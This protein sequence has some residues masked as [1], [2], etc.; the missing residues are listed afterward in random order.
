VHSNLDEVELFLNG[1]SQGRQKVVPLTHLQWQV[2]YEPGAIEAHGFKGGKLVM[3]SRRETTGA[4]ATIRL[5][6]NRS[7]LAADG[8]DIALVRVE[9]LD[10]A[11]R[12]L[13]TA[14]NLIKFKVSGEGILLGV[15]NGDPNCQES[16]IQPQ[17]S[18]FNGLAQL[19]VQATTTPG[20]MTIE[21]Y[22][23]DFPGPKLPTARMSIT[24]RRALLRPAL[25]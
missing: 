24:T 9:V 8:A 13:P 15:G 25:R 12:A 4:P 7:E 22:T 6:A 18:L 21:A 20:A 19:I 10:S 14:D 23:E 1:R 17:R 16:D 11:G 2:K 5:S 3:T